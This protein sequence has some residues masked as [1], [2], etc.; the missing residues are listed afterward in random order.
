MRHCQQVAPQCSKIY[1]ISN[2]TCG[3]QKY[4]YLNAF[5]VRVGAM[6]NKDIYIYD[7][8]YI[9]EYIVDQFLEK[10]DMFNI[11]K[12]VPLVPALQ[13]IKNEFIFTNDLPQSPKFNLERKDA[14]DVVKKL[15]SSKHVVVH[16]ISGIGKTYL[17]L[18]IVE[19][20]KLTMKGWTPLWIQGTAFKDGS[21][22]RSLSVDRVGVPVNLFGLMERFKHILIID[23]LE[24]D[25]PQV[26]ALFEEQVNNDYKLIIT[27]QTG[28]SGTT[29]HRVKSLNRDLSLKLLNSN[30]SDQCPD[31]IFEVIYKE[32]NG[33]PFLLSQVNSAVRNKETNWQKIAVQ[34]EHITA[35]ETKSSGAF[36]QSLFINHINAAE[37][38]LA[39][40]KWLDS[41]DIEYALMEMMLGT[42]GIMKLADRDFFNI[43]NAHGFI[44]HDIVFKSLQNASV[45]FDSS[46][47][48]EKLK[49]E[50]E[51]LYVDFDPK[52]YRII[53]MHSELIRRIVQR[54]KSHGFFVYCYLLTITLDDFD[55]RDVPEYRLTDIEKAFKNYRDADYFYIMSWL[56]FIELTSRQMK[57]QKDYNG[58]ADY[59]K[60]RIA[61]IK[62][63]LERP[64]KLKDHI[65]LDIKNHLGKFVRNTGADDEAIA[66]FQDILNT[67]PDFWAAKFHLAKLYR[68]KEPGI[69]QQYLMDILKAYG[70]VKG[71]SPTIVLAA[72]KEL[73]IHPGYDQEIVNR[74]IGSFD[75]LLEETMVSKFDLPYEVLGALST[76]IHFQ[77]PQKMIELTN[78]L[79]IPSENA[80]ENKTLFDVGLIYFNTA[81]AYSYINDDQRLSENAK[82]ALAYYDKLKRPGTF[83]KRYIAETYLLLKDVANALK[84]LNDVPENEKDRELWW[85]YTYSKVLVLQGKYQ[86]A[87]DK[88]NYS[89]S[90]DVNNRNASTLHRERAV[91]YD[92]MDN[93]ACLA[94]YQH[95]I[96]HCISPKFEGM[97]I[98]E[99][100]IAK[101]KFAT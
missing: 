22:L 52:F 76:K 41:Q 84:V 26:I 16:G 42:T 72:F 19:Q 51:K 49:K 17:A 66:I 32:V 40:L 18:Q 9:G 1:L 89:I 99:L 91:I 81:K 58:S 14:K 34:I 93:S 46:K 50:L 95:A 45:N 60:A 29:R 21:D 57:G 70:S 47:L 54:D 13:Q 74:F 75:Q 2:R 80:I 64:N 88:I 28:P 94:D 10:Q 61:E 15:L 82:Q 3:P 65:K 100:N 31:D 8:R 37:K 83:E 48:E 38:E 25:L 79:P 12:L 85:H 87:L 4:A 53:H 59:L 67:V 30:L 98:D 97:M 43:H 69:A 44:L 6:L 23:G 68:R 77:E 33:H 5:A 90:V 24:K 11:D 71:V 63:L 56:E 62:A 39:F 78:K 92:A 73:K 101:S 86:D 20:L 55:E 96:S 7:G 35:S 36:Y 27:S